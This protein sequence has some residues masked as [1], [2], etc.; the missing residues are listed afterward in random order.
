VAR[1]PVNI[2][3]RCDSSRYMGP[4]AISRECRGDTVGS[5]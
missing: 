1:V 2:G 5:L 4:G 3:M